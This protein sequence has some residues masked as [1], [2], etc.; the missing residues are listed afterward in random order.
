MCFE[1]DKK[2]NE[3]KNYGYPMGPQGSPGV[4]QMFR[5]SSLNKPEEEEPE[6]NVLPQV[7]PRLNKDIQSYGCRFMSLLAIPQYYLKK[8]LTAEQINNIY[9]ECILDPDIVLT[10]HQYTCKCGTKEHV[11]INKGFAA[12]GSNSTGSQVYP[13]KVLEPEDIPKG[14]DFT[15]IQ[16]STIVSGSV[17]SH[18]E[19]GTPDGRDLY[20]PGA[21]TFDKFIR[22]FFEID[23]NANVDVSTDNFKP[24][25]WLIYKVYDKA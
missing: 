13:W 6:F 17:A 22:R 14:I 3:A 18:F 12:L 15:I 7:D 8:S 5:N 21:K 19:L 9:S 23:E 25:S 2:N 10:N 24:T 4:D 1:K 16:W 11:I 20:D